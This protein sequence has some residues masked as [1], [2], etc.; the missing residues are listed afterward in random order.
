MS[1]V[2]LCLPFRVGP[3]PGAF[4]GS[5][6]WRLSDD[7]LAQQDPVAGRDANKFGDAPDRVFLELIDHAVG[8]RDVPQHLN[9]F[10]ASAVVESAF[11]DAGETI[12]IDRFAVALL[13]RSD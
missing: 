12:E 11:E 10:L 3:R 13:R 7:P 4:K 8:K 1:D 5:V 9:D 6:P 2:S